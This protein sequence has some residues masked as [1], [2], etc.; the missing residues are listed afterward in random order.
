MNS[1]LRAGFVTVTVKSTTTNELTEDL[2]SLDLQ[3]AEVDVREELVH[4][5]HH[6]G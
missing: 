4:H 5:L 6:R 2:R 1:N 3:S